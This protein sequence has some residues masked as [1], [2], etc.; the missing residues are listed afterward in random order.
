MAEDGVNFP[1]ATSFLQ[2]LIGI[3]GLRATE[4][5]RRGQF[6]G[7]YVGELLTPDEAQERRRASKAAK[8]KDIYLFALDKFV[9]PESPDPRLHQA[10]EIDGE[11]MSGP[12]RFIN[13]SCDPNLRIFAIV[14]DHANKP[15]HDL[16]FFALRDIDRFE[17][18][19]FDYLDGVD[20]EKPQEHRGRP[21]RNKADNE[22]DELT[23]TRC[24]CGAKGCRKFLWT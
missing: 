7:K 24:L 9:D 16:C 4:D 8:K 13:H 1:R 22:E 21:R 17:E 15:F 12:T 11:F 2:A 18:L 6:V 23:K 3:I 20:G 19:T 5:I 10:Y 14:N